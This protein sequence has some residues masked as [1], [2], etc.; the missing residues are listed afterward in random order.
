MKL[1]KPILK[2]SIIFLITQVSFAQPDGAPR[3]S[4]DRA[5]LRSFNGMRFSSN[6]APFQV[7]FIESTNESILVTFNI[8]VDP[9]SLKAKNIFINGAPLEKS[10]TLRFNKTGKILEIEKELSVGTKFTLEFENAKSYDG[11]EL[12]VK[13]F[14]SLLPWTSHEYPLISP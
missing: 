2:I 3:S 6:H 14:D 5:S 9:A 13:F 8:P 1:I 12:K 10:A 4:P 11:E 7:A